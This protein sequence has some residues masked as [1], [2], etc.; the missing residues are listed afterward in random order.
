MPKFRVLCFEVNAGTWA[1]HRDIEAQD[2]REAAE[3]VCGGPLVAD[4]GKPGQ[5]RAQVTP[6]GKPA[7]RTMF[8]IKG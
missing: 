6:E 2:E 4:A 3:H 8:Y 5:L 7:Q 1:E